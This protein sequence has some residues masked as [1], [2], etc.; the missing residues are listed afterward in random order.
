MPKLAEEQGSLLA[1][2][3]ILSFLALW[4]K[5]MR[6]CMEAMLG[7]TSALEARAAV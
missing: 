1:T 2:V 7:V 4:S 5:V 6:S 3:A